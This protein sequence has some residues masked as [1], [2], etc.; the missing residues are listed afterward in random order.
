MSLEIGRICYKTKGRTQ[1]S[2]VVV[3]EHLK[4]GFVTIE[5]TQT[6]RKPCNPRELFPTTQKINAT[7]ETKR[8]EIL[9]ML[10]ESA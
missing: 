7:K 9:K 1:G 3:L 4:N 2:K 8:E 6:K 5:G 10:Q